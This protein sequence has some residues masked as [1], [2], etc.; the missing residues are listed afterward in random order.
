MDTLEYNSALHIGQ[1]WWNFCP[2]A[3][4][5]LANICKSENQI[6]WKQFGI[7]Y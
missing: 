3:N 4:W 5:I 6:L 7:V 1:M 2:L